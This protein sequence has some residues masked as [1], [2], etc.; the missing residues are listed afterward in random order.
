M[1]KHQTDFWMTLLIEHAISKYT[2]TLL[3]LCVSSAHSKIKSFPYV[4]TFSVRTP[5]TENL[6]SCMDLGHVMFQ[7]ASR[8]QCGSNNEDQAWQLY[9][10][11]MGKLSVLPPAASA[12]VGGFQL[13]RFP[14]T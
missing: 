9:F 10:I 2:L 14:N 8:W 11:V 4:I 5:H 7:L 12:Y 6:S 3:Q 1:L 13:C